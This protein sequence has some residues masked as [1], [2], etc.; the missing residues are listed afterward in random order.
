MS[1]P[2]DAE[3]RL[4]YGLLERD[5]EPEREAAARVDGIDHAVVPEAGRRVIR[6]ALPFV[7]RVNRRLESRLFLR[8][9]GATLAFDDVAA[10]GREHVGGLFAAHARDARVRPG[11]QETRRV[12]TP[13]HAVVAGA[14]AAAD[15]DREL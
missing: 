6:I 13:A 4:G 11:P 8:A 15:D 2:E 9:P 3:A 14:E 12:G 7:L 5:R 1:H 10:H